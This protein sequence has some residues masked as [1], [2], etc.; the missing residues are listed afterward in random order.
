MGVIG[1]YVQ[2]AMRKDMFFLWYGGFVFGGMKL[3]G[4]GRVA[5]DVMLGWR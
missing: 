5:F 4:F 3:V 2:S 1:E